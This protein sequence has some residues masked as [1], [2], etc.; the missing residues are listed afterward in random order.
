VQGM[1]E[2]IAVIYYCLWRYNDDE[3]IAKE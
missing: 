1:N 3:I 2:I